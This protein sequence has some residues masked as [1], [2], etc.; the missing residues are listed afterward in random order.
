MTT[1]D[2]KIFFYNK[3]LQFLE[4]Y[5]KNN[6]LIKNNIIPISAISN[7]TFKKIISNDNLN[8]AL[9]RCSNTL[10]LIENAINILINQ[11]CH[12]QS[13]AINTK[14]TRIEAF[15]I[16]ANILESYSTLYRKNLK[17]WYV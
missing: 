17:N 7:D 16:K 2:K 3:I 11:F 5:C 8:Q 15:E 1:S 12:K 6:A 13:S 4:Q 10:L 14:L 9:K